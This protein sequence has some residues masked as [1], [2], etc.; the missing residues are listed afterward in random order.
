[1]PPKPRLVMAG[2]VRQ[3]L[4]DVLGEPPSRNARET[5]M[6]RVGF[7][8]PFYSPLERMQLVHHPKMLLWDKNKVDYFIDHFGPAWA[9]GMRER[10]NG[11][12]H[13]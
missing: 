12:R 1:M 6:R 2:Y 3:R 5:F 10:A 9:D 11:K 8:E 7:P 4:E 13:P